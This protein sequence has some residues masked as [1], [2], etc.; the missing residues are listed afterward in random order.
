MYSISL[1]PVLD[2]PGGP[3]DAYILAKILL[4][5]KKRPLLEPGIFKHQGRY[6]G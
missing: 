1:L 5:I 6:Q 2:D 3:L 4:S